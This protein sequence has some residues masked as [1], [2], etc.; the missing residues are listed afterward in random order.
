[1][2]VR[3]EGVVCVTGFV[4]WDG[5]AQRSRPGKPVKLNRISN[6][7]ENSNTFSCYF[8]VKYQKI[9]TLRI[10]IMAAIPD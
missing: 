8:E 5:G 4:C 9:A 2:W 10:E 3:A 7:N 1:M 6:P